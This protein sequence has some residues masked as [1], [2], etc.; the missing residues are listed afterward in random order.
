M[1]LIESNIKLW[2]Q[3][4]SNK[5]FGKAFNLANLGDFGDGDYN[6]IMC[7]VDDLV[8][9]GIADPNHLAVGGWSFGG[10]MTAWI[11]SQTDIFKAAVERLNLDL[12]FPFSST[13]HE[14][15]DIFP[16]IFCFME[17]SAY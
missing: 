7:G 5:H 17:R 3:K 15:M 13:K 1:S 10:Y 6:D 9:K 14:S 16:L 12:I 11:I 8:Q 4:Y 2:Q